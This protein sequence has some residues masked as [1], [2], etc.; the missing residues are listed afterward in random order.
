MGNGFQELIY[1]RALQ[2]EMAMQGLSAKSEFVMRIFYKEQQIGTRRVDFLVEGIIGVEI[3]A[4]TKLEEFILT[5]PS[6][7]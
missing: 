1:H 4:L 2:S 3:K 7:N 6:T 5:R